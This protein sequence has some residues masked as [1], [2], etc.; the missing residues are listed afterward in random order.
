MSVSI[1]LGDD[2]STEKPRVGL[3]MHND[4]NVLYQKAARRRSYNRVG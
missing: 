2:P 3:P 4:K 1:L